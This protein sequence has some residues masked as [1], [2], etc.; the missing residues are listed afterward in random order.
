MCFDDNQTLK[1]GTCGGTLLKNKRLLLY[2]TCHNICI[3]LNSNQTKGEGHCT[4]KTRKA[5]VDRQ[6]NSVWGGQSLRGTSC[7]PMGTN[8]IFIC[9]FSFNHPNIYLYFDALPC[10]YIYLYFGAYHTYSYIK[11]TSFLVKSHFS[12][13]GRKSTLLVF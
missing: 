1:T 2:F 7:A 10:K 4:I 5:L 12:F 9:T 6:T 11:V 13:K 8:Q 3:Y